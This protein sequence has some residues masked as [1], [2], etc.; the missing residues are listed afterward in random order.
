MINVVRHA[1]RTFALAEGGL[2]P[3][4][5]DDLLDTVGPC[6]PGATPEGFTAGAHSKHDPLTGE[7]HSLAYMMGRADVQYI[8]TG[9]D[10]R[11]VRT[12]RIPCRAHR[13][14]FAFGLERLL[15]GLTTVVTPRRPR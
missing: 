4:E 12:S 13:S 14:L 9:P 8:V 6:D 10:G 2:P 5:L 1:R 3:A 15:D 7:L 11:V